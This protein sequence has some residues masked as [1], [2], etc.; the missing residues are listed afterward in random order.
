MTFSFHPHARKELDAATD[1]YDRIAPNLG[2]A[3]LEEIADCIFRILKFPQA[4]PKLR[5]SVRRCRTH[6]FP[7]S[8]VYDLEKEQV[9]ILAVMHSSREP[10][11]WVKRIVTSQ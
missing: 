6:R 9:F 5:G 3:F 11:Y 2:D 1:Y 10:N 4:W 7:Y 8:L